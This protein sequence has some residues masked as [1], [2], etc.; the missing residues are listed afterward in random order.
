[1]SALRIRETQAAN[2]VVTLNFEILMA[3]INNENFIKLKPDS[4]LGVADEREDGLEH[5]RHIRV[6]EKLLCT[7][8]LAQNQN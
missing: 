1:M 3:I 5:A 7:C 4:D 8:Q 6:H 2:C